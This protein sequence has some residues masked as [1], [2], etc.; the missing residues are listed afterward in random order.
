LGV[1]LPKGQRVTYAWRVRIVTWNVRFGGKHELKRQIAIAVTALRAD[2]VVITEARMPSPMGDL[3]AELAALGWEHQYMSPVTD[4]KQ[5]GVLAL[6]KTPITPVEDLTAP[7][8]M[9]YRH[10]AF[11][12][13]GFDMEIMGL[14]VPPMN[15]NNVNA[16]RFWR[17]LVSQAPNWQDRP[18]MIVGDLNSGMR[19]IDEQ[20]PGLLR[21]S[22]DFRALL[23]CQLVDAYRHLHPRGNAMSWWWP[24]G[25]GMRLDHCLIAS[26]HAHR[27]VFAD[28]PAVL[29]PLRLVRTP[30]M[31]YG[32]KALSDHAAM[33][34]D[35]DESDL[36]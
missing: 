26:H 15:Q 23:S 3:Q 13:E 25:A 9:P 24:S 29:G 14:Y 34:V 19:G 2:V 5:L 16:A 12:V 20:M 1:D 17:W 36:V 35:L 4:R 33:L 22:E 30:G 8:F 18:L 6:S 28:Y 27:V 11:T 10:L 31:P 32:A 21:H 7:H